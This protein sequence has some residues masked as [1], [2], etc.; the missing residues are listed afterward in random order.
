M[1]WYL[2]KEEM[3]LEDIINKLIEIRRCLLTPWSRVLLEKLT[4]NWKMLWNG[5]EC[6]K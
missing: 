6:G 1:T 4:S 3:V 5:N 2:A